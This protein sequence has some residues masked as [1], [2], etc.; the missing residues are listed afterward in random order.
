MVCVCSVGLN[1]KDHD[2]IIQS[3]KSGKFK[4]VYQFMQEAILEKIVKEGLK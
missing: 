4:S 1:N 2:K 3:V